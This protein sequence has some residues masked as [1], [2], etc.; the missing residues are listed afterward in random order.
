MI[1][2]FNGNYDEA[3]AEFEAAISRHTSALYYY[4]GLCFMDMHNYS[5]AEK[6]FKKAIKEFVHD[7]S[8]DYDTDSDTL[9]Y[10][11]THRRRPSL[12]SYDNNNNIEELYFSYYN[13]ACVY[14]L[15]N[16]IEECKTYLRHAIEYGYPY[17]NHM[18]N[19][20]DLYNLY[21]S[22]DTEEIKLTKVLI[23]PGR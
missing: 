7:E 2:F 3:I 13:L 18:Y 23:L 1:P 11:S 10:Y 14:S 16:K 21:A 4:Y 19:D 5:D 17:L 20:P 12:Y 8:H 9:E 15:K 22:G 6:A